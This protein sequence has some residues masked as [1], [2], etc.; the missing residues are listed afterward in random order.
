MKP[1]ADEL[2]E[3]NRRTSP[4]GLFMY[5]E[6]YM[7]CADTLAKNPPA[8]PHASAPIQ[9]LIFH[10]IELY[11]KSF[12]R[13]ADIRVSDLSGRDYG[14]DFKK[15]IAGATSRGLKLRDIDIARLTFSAEKESVIQQRY[16]VTGYKRVVRSLD[17]IDTAIYVRSAVKEVMISSGVN[18]REPSW[19]CSLQAGAHNLRY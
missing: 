7:A 5:A 12:L 8:T 17:L 19:V 3:R 16:I 18:V 1:T 6:A 9:V 2:E 4:A 14:H 13:Q 11:L 15:L 10:G